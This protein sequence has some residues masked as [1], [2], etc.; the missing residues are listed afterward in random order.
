MCV[1]RIYRQDAKDTLDDELPYGWDE[2][3]ING[4]TYYIDHTTKVTVVFRCAPLT[5]Q[6]TSWLHPR[7]L[8]ETK[9]EEYRRLQQDIQSRAEVWTCLL[10]AFLYL[11]CG[12]YSR[13]SKIY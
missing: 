1:R 3:E 12:F 13:P 11:L 2:A 9:K 5:T 6:T 7:L 10:D 4:E 8:L